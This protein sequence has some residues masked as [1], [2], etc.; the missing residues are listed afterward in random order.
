[1]SLSVLEQGSLFRMGPQC[2]SLWAWKTQQAPA[3]PE[4]RGETEGTDQILGLHTV[5]PLSIHG[6]ITKVQGR[7]VAL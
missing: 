6:I 7:D 3:E 4:T 5:M 1:M 2:H